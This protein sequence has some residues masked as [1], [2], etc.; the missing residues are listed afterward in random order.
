MKEPPRFTVCP[1]LEVAK[2][3][4]DALTVLL[5]VVEIAPLPP[6]MRM[7]ATCAPVTLSVPVL[8]KVILLLTALISPHAAPAVAAK[9]TGALMVTPPV[10]R[11]SSFACTP[12]LSKR[13]STEPP[14]LFSTHALLPFQ[15]S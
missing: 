14:E 8:P 9:V 11:L 15:L 1:T 3:F 12:P 5:K 6:N 4:P 2:Y 7:P 13:L 10:P